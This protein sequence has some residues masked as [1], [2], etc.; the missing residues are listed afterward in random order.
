MP[1]SVGPL[2]RRT[3]PVRSRG[4]SSVGWLVA[5][6]VLVSVITLVLKLG[7]HYIDFYTMK[8]V[9]EGLPAAE[10]HRMSRADIDETLTKRFKVN[11][12]RDFRIRD[13]IDI[14][15]ARDVTALTV[16]YERREHLLLNLDVVIT[17]DKRY[18]Y[19]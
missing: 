6:V 9:I 5:L 2:V 3:G 1:V 17:F 8:S 19:R 12:L 18:E 7:P 11:N 14:E 4:L 16:E 13:I 15:R 10:V